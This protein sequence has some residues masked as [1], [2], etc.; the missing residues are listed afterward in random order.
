MLLSLN[1]KRGFSEILIMAPFHNYLL[2]GKFN[3]KDADA[4][5]Y[6]YI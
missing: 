6:I 1:M 3:L 5:I 4:K 2:N